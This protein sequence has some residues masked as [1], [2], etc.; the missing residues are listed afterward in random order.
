VPIEEL[1][2]DN[3]IVYDDGTPRTKHVTTNIAI[4]VDEEAG[5][6]VSRSYFTAL[7]ALPDLA[8]QPIV[9]GR[10]EDRFE[11]RDGQWRFAERR[12]LT[13]LVGDVSRHLRRSIAI[14]SASD[15]PKQ[16]PMP[17]NVPP[18]VM[19][20]FA[21]DADHDVE[22]IV[23][24]FTEDATVT[25]EGETRRGI[26]AIRAWRAGA[27]AEYDY[28]T[29]I[30]GSEDRGDR[31]FRVTARLVGN[32]PGGT[33]DLNFDFTVENDHIRALKIAP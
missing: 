1:L 30:T 20:Y 4:E 7:Q 15:T 33:A 2:R 3:V 21:L 27:A 11:H 28:A 24:L 6:A 17:D 31:Q 29:T 23:A 9:S 32:F 16:E 5:T 14:R 26:D 25:D 13:D 19:R 8:L 18:I 10:Y 12:V 22:P